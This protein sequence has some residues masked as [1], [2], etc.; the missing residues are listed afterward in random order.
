VASLK[1][2]RYR[3]KTS[4][5]RPDNRLGADIFLASQGSQTQIEVQCLFGYQPSLVGTEDLAAVPFSFFVER[6]MMGSWGLVCSRVGRW[7]W[8]ALQ[9]GVLKVDPKTTPLP[10]DPA[11]PEALHERAAA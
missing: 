7:T 1:V 6:G 9:G 5:W 11:H 4:F 3:A 10:K 8:C 2:D